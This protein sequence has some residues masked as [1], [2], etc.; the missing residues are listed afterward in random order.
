M[1]IQPQAV[2]FEDDGRTPN[3]PTL[4]TLIYS[5]A[6]PSE[7]DLTTACKALFK[8][9]GW[10]GVWVNG[11]FSFHHYH[12]NAH[13]VLGVTSGTATLMLGGEQGE[14]FAVK[15]GDVIVIPA[16]VGHCNLGAS[17]DFTVVGAYPAGQENYDL[18]R[19]NPTDYDIARDNIPRV[20][21]PASDPIFGKTGPLVSLWGD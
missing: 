15:A 3:N 17:G 14:T 12:S 11:V 4:P 9:H 8:E 10:R 21:L 2:H 1:T 7:G 5:Q 16:G 19:T 20:S 13:E 6:L 18:R